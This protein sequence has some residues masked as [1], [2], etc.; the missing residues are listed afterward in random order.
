MGGGVGGEYGGGG[1]AALGGGVN[2]G[3][4]RGEFYG[5]RGGTIWYIWVGAT[6]LWFLGMKYLDTIR[7]GT[8][9]FVFFLGV[10]FLFPQVG[11]DLDVATI[12]TIG[13]FLFAI[14]AGFFISRLSQR[15]DNI[16]NEMAVED[17]YWVAMYRTSTLLGKKFSDQVADIIDRYYV[18]LYD[19]DIGVTYQA[20]EQEVNNMYLALNK[21]EEKNNTVAQTATTEIIDMLEAVE[22]GRNKVAA[23]VE[24]RLSKGHW[25]VLVILMIIILASMLNMDRSSFFMQA[26]AVLLSTSLAIVLLI[27]R[28]LQNLRFGGKIL[29]EESGEQVF[30]S[31]GRLRYYNRAFLEE[32]TVS[33]P[34]HI[35]KYRVGHFD[36][37]GKKVVEI[38]ER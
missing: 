11:T 32:G 37:R 9:V 23:L 38:V 34:K 7:V 10:Y 21:L 3:I 13:T 4:G 35:K 12:M 30:E 26:S 25:L 22:I 2:I 17:A 16:R 19:H 6:N 15:Y 8:M 14:L 27:I 5:L 1:D 28:D 36:K 18:I 24:E 20:S 29:M 31:V 33:V